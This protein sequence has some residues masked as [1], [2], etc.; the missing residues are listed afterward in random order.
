MNALSQL[1][2][3]ELDCVAALVNTTGD[4]AGFRCTM[5]EIP[6]LGDDAK[7]GDFAIAY[8]QH[9]LNSA[10]A[11]KSEREQIEQNWSNA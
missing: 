3:L 5:R 10:L 7:L 6:A 8:L 4:N 11:R 9:M 2:A 1:H